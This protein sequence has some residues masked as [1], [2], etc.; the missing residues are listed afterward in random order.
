MCAF[1]VVGSNVD[2]LFISSINE[3]SAARAF[4]CGAS[5][6]CAVVKRE[7]RC[8]VE[9]SGG[10]LNC[11]VDINLNGIG[12]CKVPVSAFPFVDHPRAG[13]LKD[14]TAAVPSHFV[15]AGGG[16]RIAGAAQGDSRCSIRS[17]GNNRAGDI[18]RFVNS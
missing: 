12:C 2:D 4:E 5:N 13:I 3:E 16:C 8:V 1:V 17:R 18:G 14:N 10:R 15:L 6:F 7:C 11:T 9:C